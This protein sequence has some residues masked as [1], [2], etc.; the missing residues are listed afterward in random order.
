[1]QTLEVQMHPVVNAIL[2]PDSQMME[3]IV[4]VGYGSGKKVGSIVGSVSTVG[5][6]KFEK[7]PVAN[8]GDALQGQ[9]AGLQVFTPS[10]EPS[11]SVK[12]RLRGVSSINASTDP[13]FVLDGS[14]ISIGAFTA[15][16]PNDIES[17]TILKDASATAIYGSRAA[18]GVVILTSKKGKLGEKARVNVSAQYGISKMVGDNVTMMNVEQYLNFQEIL[19][20]TKLNDAAFQTEKKFYIDNGISTDWS[21][22]FFGKSAPTSQVDMSVTGGTSG[23]SYFLSFG[24][25]QADGIMDD[26]SL[27][28]ETLRSN[29]DAKVNDWIKVGANLA[30]SYQKW[31]LAAFGTTSNSVYNKA[32]ASRVYRPDQSYYEILT[33]DNGNFLGYGERLKE[34]E[35]LGYYN[36]YYLSEIQPTTRDM[37]RING[38]TYVNLNPLKGLNIR[39]AQAVEAFDYRL[40]Q[41][42]YPEGPFE[43]AG[44]RTERFQ[45]YYSFTYTNTAE[46]KFTVV[47]YNHF[48]FL[49]GQESIIT[50]NQEFGGSGEGLTDERLM[51][52]TATKADG[53]S[54]THTL[55]D[56]VF[57]SYFGTLS[58]NF[59]EKYYADFAVRRDGSSLFGV[60]NQWATF[61]SMGAMW[62]IKK[63]NF[64][65]RI[66]FLDQLQLKVSYGT[67]GN[68][69]I[70][71]YMAL[72]L[73]SSGSSYLYN[74]NPGTAVGNPSNPSLS[75]ETVKSFNLGLNTRLFDRVNIDLEFYN[76]KTEDMLME[77][78][79]SFTTG[80]STGWAN[81]A[82]MRNRGIDFTTTID[83]IN[84]KEILW[85]FSANFNYNK[86]KVLSLYDGVEE[87][88]FT[89]GQYKV[90]VGKPFGEFYYV[91]WA[92]VDPRDG[93][94]MWYDKNGNL[95][96][97]YSEEDKVFTGK[98]RFAPWSGGFSTR[99]T[100]RGISVAADFS[101]LL[102]QYM[103]N[104]ERWFTENPTFAG[105]RNQ[106]TKMLTIWTKP[107]DI[108]DISTPE[109]A[110]QF[111][112]HLLENASFLR[113]KNITIGYSFPQQL[114]KQTGFVQGAKVF[115]VGRNLLTFTKYKGFD[116]EVD[117]SVQLGNYPNTK[118]YSVGFELTF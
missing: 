106:T 31:N 86:N 60:D 8:I 110:M 2:K 32:Y 29:V 18:N 4:I 11:E 1:M 33:D 45:R 41:K 9:V 38:N 17:M 12:M 87:D 112:T 100:W 69:G 52:L 108:T 105:S 7:R 61:Y 111:D 63:E 77:V 88:G 35:K 37:V 92:G 85:D 73:V 15:L 21:K 53:R 25:Y 103:L 34:F 56:K 115:V 44:T 68:S 54:F 95:T 19:D 10:G 75:W 96:K 113:L 78:P 30:L 24:H 107:G 101:W 13:L 81:V 22:I 102:K 16:N 23:V 104:N 58:Y 67:T 47:D 48:T 93:Y 71:S 20:P 59:D 50:K 49:L 3:E 70:D 72:G 76:R 117:S 80:F 65:R 66:S 6:D 46:Y 74:G 109:S 91:K 55:Y 27:R 43:G 28:R 26:S 62:D 79:L 64:L 99:F 51:L 14:P 90:E 42:V 89:Y 116:P 82:S 84:N 97:N 83:I 98:Q 57:N 94:N 40:S 118:Q 36:P 5:G 114:L 39:A